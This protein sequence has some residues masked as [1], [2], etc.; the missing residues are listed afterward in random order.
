MK[1]YKVTLCIID[2]DR[3]GPEGIAS[4][5]E[6]AH[7]ANRCISPQV[8]ACEDQD[9]GEWSDDNPLNRRDTFD[10]EFRRLFPT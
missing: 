7:Y 1:V 3:L 8:M 5:L 2:H 9:I 6:N 4:A 10:A